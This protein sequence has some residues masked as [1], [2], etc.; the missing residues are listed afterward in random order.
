MRDLVP[1]SDL[2]PRACAS[3]VQTLSHWTTREIPDAILNSMNSL[4][5]QITVHAYMWLFYYSNSNC[6]CYA[7]RVLGKS[8]V[9]E[10]IVYWRLLCAMKA[11]LCHETGHETVTES[12]ATVKIFRVCVLSCLSHAWLFVTLWTVA[13]QDPLSMEFP[14]QEYWSGFSCPPPGDLPEPGIKPPSPALQADSLLLSH[15]A[16]AM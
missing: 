10:I 3:G 15:W 4:K 14:R 12:K 16:T 7:W 8:E 1:P 6:H 13:L 11:T 9:M 2:K 5:L